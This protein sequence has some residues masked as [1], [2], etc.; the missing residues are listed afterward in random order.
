MSKKT[1]IIIGVV[2]AVLIIGGYGTYLN[3]NKESDT[4][5]SNQ[6]AES[7]TPTA[8]PTDTPTPEPTTAPTDTPTPDAQ[9]SEANFL[10]F[11]NKSL[12][13]STFK[14][15]YKITTDDGSI[16]LSVWHEGV[17]A[18]IVAMQMTAN[19][20]ARKVYEDMK[21]EMGTLATNMYNAA[22][23]YHV[24]DKNIGLYVLND[25][26]LDNVLLGWKNGELFYEAINE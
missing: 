3:K 10:K 5:S 8:K 13:E 22:R 19:D 26:N 23:T 24:N 20:E 25:K 11:V 18:E 6:T 4:T 21:T 17:T 1:K 15:N 9:T 16:V 14:D 7:T 12:K 2:I